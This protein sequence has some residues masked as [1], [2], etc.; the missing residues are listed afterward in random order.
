ME[1][2]KTYGYNRKA[3]E[4]IMHRRQKQIETALQPGDT[5][6]IDKGT[7]KGRRAK[8][9]GGRMYGSEWMPVFWVAMPSGKFRKQA[10]GPV[11]VLRL[12]GIKDVPE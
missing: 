3:Y 9:I 7:Y 2:N 1:E 8:Y 6:M 5:I 12:L 11:T 10:F 4:V